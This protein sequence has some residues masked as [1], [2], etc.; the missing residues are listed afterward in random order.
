MDA[1]RG[2][3]VLLAVLVCSDRWLPSRY[4]DPCTTGLPILQHAWQPS[5]SELGSD[6]PRP[7]LVACGLL[8]RDG[9]PAEDSDGDGRNVYT[10]RIPLWCPPQPL[11]GRLQTFPALRAERRRRIRRRCTRC[12]RTRHGR[13]KRGTHKCRRRRL[14]YWPFFPAQPVAF[15]VFVFFPHLF[16]EVVREIRRR[17]GSGSIDGS[18]VAP[19]V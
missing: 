11:P 8:G 7:W 9:C 14:P 13:T 12:R 15:I 5:A 16:F 19:V 6:G 18:L 3:R 4:V 10:H 1:I 17:E 2:M